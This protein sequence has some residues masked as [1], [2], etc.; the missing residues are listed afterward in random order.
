MARAARSFAC[1]SM[2]LGVRFS[3]LA[4][5]PHCR[6]LQTPIAYILSS[7]VDT[8]PMKE[9]PDGDIVGVDWNCLGLPHRRVGLPRRACHQR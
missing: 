3:R 5:K 8:S 2:I 6:R 1:G 7:R 9:R 4:R